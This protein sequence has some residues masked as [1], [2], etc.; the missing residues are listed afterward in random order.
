MRGKLFDAQLQ[1]SI[2]I[3]Y[4]VQKNSASEDNLMKKKLQQLQQNVLAKSHNGQNKFK[5]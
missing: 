5:Y 3:N 2:N 1:D 4:S